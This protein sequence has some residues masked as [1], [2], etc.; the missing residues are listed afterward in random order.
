MQ[1]TLAA[2]GVGPKAK[3]L[4][5]LPEWVANPSVAEVRDKRPGWQLSFN[6]C[7]TL[8][9]Q[10][11]CK[12]NEQKAGWT[13]DVAAQMLRA[14]AISQHAACQ[15]VPAQS[16]APKCVDQ[17]ASERQLQSELSRAKRKLVVVESKLEV[18][19]IK[20]AKAED[21]VRL[22]T[23][24]K[25]LESRA[26][27]HRVEIDPMNDTELTRANKSTAKLTSGSGIIDT[28]KYWATTLEILCLLSNGMTENLQ[29]PTAARLC[30]LKKVC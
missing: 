5:N 11:R 26:E 24:Q 16:E 17:S 7:C 21:A 27:K 3:L 6:C 15:P 10:V 28:I 23:E 29:T 9:R 20:V 22:V 1:T 19:S 14:A 13:L 8:D 25:R 2:C 12:A 18:N 4:S 30:Q